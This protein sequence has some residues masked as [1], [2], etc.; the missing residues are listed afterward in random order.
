MK[1]SLSEILFW[2][3]FFALIALFVI[4]GYFT[5]YPY[6][7]VRVD[8]IIP[9]KTEVCRGEELC[10]MFKGEKFYEMPV[11]ILVELTN[12][13]RYYVMRYTSNTPKGDVF[14]RRC[15]IVPNSVKPNNYRIEWTGTYKM[16]MLREVHKKGYSGWIEVK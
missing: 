6:T 2:A 7:P 10:F 3:M 16:N 15:F 9:D 11:E 12:G 5:W 14:N 13:E 4:M 8:G 1:N